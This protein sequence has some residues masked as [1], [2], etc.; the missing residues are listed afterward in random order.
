MNKN[1]RK[2]TEGAMICAI[3]GMLLFLNMQSG[4]VLEY[5]LMFV[6]PLGM[7]VYRVRHD[8][9]SS[10]A[11]AI[12]VLFLTFLMGIPTTYFLFGASLISG[13]IYSSALLKQ[14]SRRHLL[15]IAMVTS[16][17]LNFIVSYG[18]AGFFG[19]DIEATFNEIETI[20]REMY[21]GSLDLIEGSLDDI[22][23]ASYMITIA[24]TAI[25]EGLLVHWSSQILFKRLKIKVNTVNKPISIVGSRPLGYVAFIFFSCGIILSYVKMNEMVELLG[26]VLHYISMVYLFQFGFIG[27]TLLGVVY[28]KRNIA[29]I[30]VVTFMIL[31]LTTNIAIYYIYF[32]CFVG[33]IYLTTDYKDRIFIMRR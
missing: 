11:V 7:I 32:I 25:F 8:L 30:L 33:F 5:Q 21:P 23:F 6:L 3:Y 27:L 31:F 13:I 14:V 19:I 4:F 18:L 1:V 20:T 15:I 22:I 9:A 26:M 16:F 12:S 28:L 29:M 24:F 2:I 10:I 17:L